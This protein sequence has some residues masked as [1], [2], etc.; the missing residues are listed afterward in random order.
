MCGFAGFWSM[1]GMDD[2][3]ACLAAMA[4]A[5]VHRGPDGEGLRFEEE[6]GVGLAHRRLAIIDL[7]AEGAQ[8][9]ESASGRYLIAYNGEIYNYISIRE[10]LGI[11]PGAYRGHS[12]TEVLLA[13]IERWGLAPAVGRF[14]G[15]FAFALWDRRDRKLHLVRDRLGIK[16]LYYGRAG[17]QLVFGSDPA[18]FRR[19]PG[20]DG[21]VDRDALALFL[22]FN[23]VPAPYSIYRGIRK[24]PAGCVVTFDS[25][26][27]EPAPQPYWR[28]IDA[29]RDGVRDP[30]AGSSEEAV[31]GLEDLLTEA[32][33]SRM[34]SD[35]PLG[36]FLSGGVDSSVVVALMQRAS[37]RPVKTFSIGFEVA[38]FD[39][40]PFARDVARH[41]GTDHH[42]LYV[43]PG[44]CLDVIPDLPRFYSEPFS[45]SSQIPTYLVSRL[46]REHVTVSLSGDG[47]DELFAGYNRYML[48]QRLWRVIER[49]PDPLL[50]A[51]AG[52]IRNIPPDTWDRVL[53]VLRPMHRGRSIF[54][55]SGDKFHKLSDVLTA[56]DFPS[57]Y[58]RLVSHWKQPDRV[59]LG[60]DEPRGLIEDV[61]H[62]LDDLSVTERMMYWDLMTYLPDDILVKVDRASMAVGLEARVPLI[63]HRVVEFAWR[64][65]LAFKKRGACSK[66]ALRQVLY[67]HVPSAL[68]DRP[69]KGFG[70]PLDRWL[71]VE[72]KD[73]A[74]SLLD[75]RRLAAEGY[76]DP[77]VIRR[78]W[79]EHQSGKRRWQYYL[80]DVLMFQAWLEDARRIGA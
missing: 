12:D 33:T 22:R 74:E 48:G 46:A 35:V 67:R 70:V 63:D 59:V 13:A 11:D 64:L 34:V 54:A 21:E 56:S 52:T 40:A 43:T 7:S 14:A 10:S 29:I 42:E 61:E 39:E 76:F 26:D 68:I 32:V 18:S 4:A 73:W 47:G 78:Y 9:M 77:D 44:D 62:V 1:G 27:S 37:T 72:L 53:G 8:P 49:T 19:V 79:D 57:L 65:P 66:W 23:C 51:G 24:L 31:D 50:R 75:R 15:M 6:S 69:K 17:R 20:F 60:S 30:F 5:Q 45:D 58:R 16:P 41:L 28:A 3:M 71:R 36:A 38:E 2:P 80:W 25:A 55:L